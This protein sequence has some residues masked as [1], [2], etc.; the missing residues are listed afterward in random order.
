LQVTGAGFEKFSGFYQANLEQG[1]SNID[2]VE[3]FSG[4]LG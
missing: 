4:F 2:F 1:I 3:N